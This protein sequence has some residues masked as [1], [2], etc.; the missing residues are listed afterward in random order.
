MEENLN[1]SEIRFG[2]LQKS[3]LK[4]HCNANLKT[5]GLLVREGADH[6]CWRVNINSKIEK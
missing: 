4:C 6:G 5:K 1:S 3:S 2:D